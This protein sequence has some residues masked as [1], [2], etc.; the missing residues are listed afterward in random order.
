[1]VTDLISSSKTSNEALSQ[2]ISILI[3]CVSKD[4]LCDCSE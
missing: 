2:R 4:G 1:M 3:L